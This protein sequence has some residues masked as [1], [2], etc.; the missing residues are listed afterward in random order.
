MKN[1]KVFNYIRA[2]CNAFETARQNLLGV[3]IILKTIRRLEA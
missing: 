2:V 3:Q 1:F